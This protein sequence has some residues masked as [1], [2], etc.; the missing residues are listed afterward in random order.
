[1]EGLKPEI[2]SFLREAV[3][4][5]ASRLNGTDD[6]DPFFS[7]SDGLDPMAGGFDPILLAGGGGG[8]LRGFEVGTI[9]LCLL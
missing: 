8:V 2:T 6:D 5:K 4:R 3:L 1:M 9:G 7:S